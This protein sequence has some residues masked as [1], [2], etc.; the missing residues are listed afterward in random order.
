M[1]TIKVTSSAA[2]ADK[3]FVGAA[4]S[5]G[6]AQATGKS[7]SYIQVLIQDDAYIMFGTD[8]REPSAFVEVRGIGAYPKGS[9]AE[10]SRVICTVLSGSAGIPGKRIYINFMEFNASKWGCDSTTF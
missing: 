6:I 1:P 3:S 9:E 4:L 7:E 5:A 10:M 8:A 2:I